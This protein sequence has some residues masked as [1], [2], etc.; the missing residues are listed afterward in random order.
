MIH[1]GK[2][3]SAAVRSN[4]FIVEDGD[5][6]RSGASADRRKLFSDGGAL[7]SHRY[8]NLLLPLDF[9]VSSLT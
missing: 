6:V 4:Q 8:A 9:G 2:L 7:P 1:A 5:S 3:D